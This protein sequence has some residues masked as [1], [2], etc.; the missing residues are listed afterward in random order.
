MEYQFF[1]WFTIVVV[2]FSQTLPLPPHGASRYVN[3]DDGTVYSKL[4]HKEIKLKTLV[5]QAHSFICI[6]LH[7]LESAFKYILWFNLHLPWSRCCW[8]HTNICQYLYSLAGLWLST[9]NTHN[10]LCEGALC[11]EHYWPTGWARMLG[12]H[13]PR[14]SRKPVMDRS[15]W[16]DISISLPLERTTK[17]WN[18]MW[19]KVALEFRLSLSCRG[20]K[21]DQVSPVVP[22]L[23]FMPG[24]E[25]QGISTLLG[26]VFNQCQMGVGI[27]MTQPPYSFSRIILSHV[28]Y[29]G[30]WS[31]PVGLSSS[32]P[33]WNLPDNVPF[34]A[35]FSPHLTSA[36]PQ[37]PFPGVIFHINHLHTNSY[38]GVYFWGTQPKTASKRWILLLFQ[39]YIWKQG[40]TAN[41]SDLSKANNQ[42]K[43][44]ST[45]LNLP[46]G[47]ELSRTTYS[48]TVE[49]TGSYGHVQ[50]FNL[51]VFH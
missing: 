25:H 35:S 23:A 50:N 5:S 6:A 39:F 24:Q 43:S 47:T 3:W 41:P 28:F 44:C 32:C 33:Q 13:F 38:L 29:T 12:S 51:S 49:I 1:S 9:G 42:W 16:I 10:S 15:C 48:R 27:Y 46:V 34:I 45:H 20:S 11:L 17:C 7:G 21:W 26:A 37:P 40:G 36:Y 22:F 2:C 8:C 4:F 19:A 31:F 30:F 14:D 18:W